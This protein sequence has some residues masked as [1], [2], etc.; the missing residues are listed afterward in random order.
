MD[1]EEKLNNATIAGVPGGLTAFGVLAW[2]YLPGFRAKI[3]VILVSTVDLMVLSLIGWLVCS[4]W[5]PKPALSLFGPGNQNYC[6]TMAPNPAAASAG[7]PFLLQAVRLA[8]RISRIKM[9]MNSKMFCFLISFLLLGCSKQSQIDPSVLPFKVTAVQTPETTELISLMKHTT[10]L[11]AAKDYP[12]LDQLAAKLRS[13]KERNADGVWKL[14][15]LY[16][17]LSISNNIFGMEMYDNIP[18][19]AYEGRIAELRDWVKA[20]P[21]SITARVALASVQVDYAW[22]A[23]GGGYANTVTAEGWKGFGERLKEA[24]ET[25]A[26]AKRLPI[27]CPVYWCVAMDVGLGLE[28]P[29]DRLND[30][31]HEA[32]N[33]QPDFMSFYD[34]RANLLL[35]RWDGNHGEWEN[36]LAQSADNVGGADGDA[37]YTQV[38]WKLNRSTAFN[39]IFQE[40]NLSWPRVKKG[41]EVLEKRYPNSLAVKNEGLYLAVFAQDAPAARKYF[42]DTQGQMDE[43]IWQTQHEFIAFAIYGYE[44]SK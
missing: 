12:E 9:I 14:S 29:K 11:L 35:P 1:L 17:A 36:D 27:K 28:L 23:R 42:V 44:K 41:L 3:I 21:D 38:V 37:L 2:M 15:E 5:R 33:Y 7:T 8:L 43:S 10:T 40:N 30:I 32:I 31:F 26:A 4:S 39:N 6:A 22:N 16:Y 20:R 13:S 25:L 24:A 18:D 34:C 19:Q